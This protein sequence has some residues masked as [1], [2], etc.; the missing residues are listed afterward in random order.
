MERQLHIERF[1]K[2]GR[3]SN[4][5]VANN[6]I[7]LTGQV[8]AE[9]ASVIDQTRAVLASIDRLLEAAGSDRSKIVQATVLL[10]DIDD[11]AAMNSVWDDWV[12]AD[13][14]PA[15]ATYE[16]RLTA[17]GYKV[18]IVVVALAT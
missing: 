1:E 14:P 9:G 5:V 13:N 8:G 10:A 12:D 4:A 2:S 17:P 15:R 11:F 6:T 18:E 3:L 7:Y 16:A